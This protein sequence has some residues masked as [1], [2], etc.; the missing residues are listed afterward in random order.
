MRLSMILALA[1]AEV[2]SVRRLMRYWMFSVLAIVSAVMAYLYF[3]VLHGLFSG[4]SATVGAIGPRNLVGTVGA[5]MV[6][7]FTVGLI[8]LAFDVRARDERERMAEVLD[9]RPMSNPELLVGRSLALVLMAWAPVLVVAILLQTFGTVA[10]SLDWY[11][12]EPVEPYSLTGFALTT[13]TVCALWCTVVMLLAVLLRNRLLVALAALVLLGLQVWGTANMPVYLVQVLD[14]SGFGGGGSDLVPTLMTADGVVRLVSLGILAAGGIALAAAWHPRP[15]GGSRSRRVA[16][17]VGLVALAGLAIGNQARQAVAAMDVRAGWRAAH[18]AHRDDPRPDLQSVTGA[19]RIAPGRRVELTLDLRVQAPPDRSLDTLL[20]TFNPGLTV[21]RVAVGGAEAVWTHTTGLLEVTPAH[22]LAPG[23]ETA[24]S[25]VASGRPDTAFGYLDAEW[26]VA[27]GSIAN[28]QIGLLG[29][30]VGIFSSRYVALMPGLGWLPH[31]G[32]D[33]PAGDPRTHPADFFEVE[34]EV[35]VPAGWLVAGPGRRE[36]LEGD[37]DT[38]RFRFHPGAPVPHVGLLASRFERRAVEVAG[39]ELEVLVH[40]THDRNLRFFADAADEI[41]ARAEEILTDAERL[42]LPY[43]YGGLTVVESPYTS[44]GLWRRVAHGHDPDD[45]W[46]LAAPGEQ[47]PDVSVRVRAARPRPLRRAR[48]RLR[49]GQGRDVGALLRERRQRWQPV[50]RRV[51]E[52]LALPDRAPGV[53]VRW[54]S[55]SCSTS[56]PPGCSPAGGATSQRS[57]SRTWAPWPQRPSPPW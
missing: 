45:A 30:S 1:R 19:V 16:F 25:L 44:A 5:G 39:V 29:A 54:R 22:A 12:G 4:F 36:S 42:G 10:L 55:T 40:P 13:L 26:D 21:E 50:S 41:A 14:L 24:V 28:A 43:P 18:Q 7:I 33:V 9:S 46:R 11:F 3:A 49:G 35:E 23:M 32:S 47:L 37:G 2:R 56:S 52:L 34:L 53:R 20:F 48:G 15:D 8:F 6:T 17:G 57:Y 31:P 51:P 38:A 27:S